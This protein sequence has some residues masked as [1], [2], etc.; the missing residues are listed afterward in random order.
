M[1]GQGAAS[2]WPTTLHSEFAQ[3]AHGSQD[4][5]QCA[6]SNDSFGYA[7]HRS[8]AVTGGTKVQGSKHSPFAHQRAIRGQSPVPKHI[9]AVVTSC[10]SCCSCA[11]LKPGAK[12]G[13]FASG[14]KIA[15]ASSTHSSHHA[16]VPSC[17]LPQVSTVTPVWS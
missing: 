1:R 7:S 15:Y 9:Q 17:V 6:Y 10:R 11:R 14:G 16:Q 5:M 2:H 4:R 3:S 13:L 12:A 8:D